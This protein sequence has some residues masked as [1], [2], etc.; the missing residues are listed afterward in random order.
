MKSPIERNPITERS[1]FSERLKR[2]LSEFDSTLL[3]ATVLAREFNRRSKQSTISTT[4]AYKWLSAESIPQQEK[5]AFLANWLR[6]PVQW[7]RFGDETDT[8]VMSVRDKRRQ[9]KLLSDY[10]TLTERD[11]KLIEIMMRELMR[12]K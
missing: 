9:D 10:A 4:T 2:A 7:L 5:L 3:S 1:A 8:T 12:L 11:K 6:V